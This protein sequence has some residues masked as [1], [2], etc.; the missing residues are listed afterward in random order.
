MLNSLAY[1]GI[2]GG[3]DAMLSVWRKVGK[4][5]QSSSID[6]HKIIT[7]KVVSWVILFNFILNKILY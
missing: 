4:V 5:S 1:I 7:L 6:N 2:V 3:C